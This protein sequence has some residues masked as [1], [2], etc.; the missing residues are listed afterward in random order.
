MVLTERGQK[1]VHAEQQKCYLQLSTKM[2]LALYT[3]V[4]D[5]LVCLSLSP[6]QKALYG[7]LHR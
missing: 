1:T 7:F 2:V 3:G 6:M 5:H 4:P